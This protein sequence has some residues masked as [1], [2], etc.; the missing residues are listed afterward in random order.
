MPVSF[1][2]CVKSRL[3]FRILFEQLPER[4]EFVLAETEPFQSERVD[5]FARNGQISQRDTLKCGPQGA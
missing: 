4:V 5:N 2:I 3:V 1:E